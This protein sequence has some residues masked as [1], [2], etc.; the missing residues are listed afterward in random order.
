MS[1][2]IV[3]IDDVVFDWQENLRKIMKFS[4]SFFF[5]LNLW[6]WKEKKKVL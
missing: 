6:N 1:L 3:F 4:T 5:F 2:S